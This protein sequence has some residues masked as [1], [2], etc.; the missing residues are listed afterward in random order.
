MVSKIERSE[1]G[2]GLKG[3][4]RNK[5]ELGGGVRRVVILEEEGRDRTGLRAFAERETGMSDEGEPM[6]GDGF[7]LE[8]GFDGEAKKD[9][10]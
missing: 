9:L 8:Q 2:A 6:F 5:L 3:I 4:E 7:E 1:G 10:Q